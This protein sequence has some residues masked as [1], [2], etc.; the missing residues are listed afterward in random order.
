MTDTPSQR[1]D[2]DDYAALFLND[3]PLIDTRAPVEFSQGAFPNSVNLPLM[4]DEE[5]A[6]VGT[7]YK[8]QGQQAA[9]ELGHQLVSGELKRQRVSAWSDFARAHPEGYIYC[10]RGGLRSQTSRQWMRDAGSDYPL[11]KGGYKA[12]RRFLIDFLEREAQQRCWL[13]LSGRTGTGKT[14][15]IDQVEASV[16]LEGLANHRGSSFGRQVTEQPTQ[17]NFENALAIDLLKLQQRFDGP[18]MLEDES[19]LIGRLDIPLSLF[20]EMSQ[21][22]IA[23]LEEP[24]TLRVAQVREDYVQTLSAD[25][26]AAYGDDEGLQRY[27]DYL[28]ASLDRVRKRLGAERHA[29]I[30][31]LMREA[32]ERQLEQGEVELH[33]RWIEAM[34]SQ[35]YDPMYDYQLSKKTERV[36]MRGNQQEVLEW[37]QVYREGF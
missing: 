20:N 8:Q 1:P 37:F 32:L 14:R 22:P 3:A 11:V 33:D 10:F 7:C 4:S 15:V 2:T 18:V 21:A 35:Y 9:I 13:I 34:L 26:R 28:L 36:K 6:Q 30:R 29:Q 19:R 24:M 17:I 27:A 16:D 25:Y 5:R 23:V 12:M 31:Q